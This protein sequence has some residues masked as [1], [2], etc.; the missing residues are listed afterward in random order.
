VNSFLGAE[1][2]YKLLGD[3]DPIFASYYR[4]LEADPENFLYRDIPHALEMMTDGRSI[5]HGNSFM[6]KNFFK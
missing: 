2:F 3:S 5:I 1:S 6:L 4:N